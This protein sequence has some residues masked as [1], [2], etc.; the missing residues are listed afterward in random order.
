MNKVQTPENSPPTL[1]LGQQVRA[2]IVGE[3]AF[4][5]TDGADIDVAYGGGEYMAPLVLTEA[6]V[7]VVP[8]DAPTDL[9]VALGV[10]AGNVAD[11]RALA[12]RM[13][14]MSAEARRDRA[15]LVRAL[16]IDVLVGVGAADRATYVSRVEE[17]DRLIAVAVARRAE[18][19]AL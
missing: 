2:T 18:G 11:L 17:A 7:S 14:V 5:S 8:A 15:D 19:G 16:L 3:V 9:D 4:V 10:L 13:T 12:P 1:V 6:G